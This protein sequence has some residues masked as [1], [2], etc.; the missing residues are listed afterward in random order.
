MKKA[1]QRPILKIQKAFG[2]KR[3]FKIKFIMKKLLFLL[4][5]TMLMTGCESNKDEYSSVNLHRNNSFNFVIE[6]IANNSTTKAHLEGLKVAFDEND[7][8]AIYDNN[9]AMSEYTYSSSTNK[10]SGNSSNDLY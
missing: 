3:L 10:F 1:L 8:I 9:T 4:S 7:K 5:I 2:I 6:P